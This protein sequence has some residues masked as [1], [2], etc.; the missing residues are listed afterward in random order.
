MSRSTMHTEARIDA[1]IVRQEARRAPVRPEAV[2]SSI[3]ERIASATPADAH[4]APRSIA[5]AQPTLSTPDNASG[6]WHPAATE[7]YTCW[8]CGDPSIGSFCLACHT[9]QQQ[10]EADDARRPA[11]QMNTA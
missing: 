2:A 10:E 8:D 7:P 5:M 1:Y 4:I 3:R 11:H 6:A 9:R